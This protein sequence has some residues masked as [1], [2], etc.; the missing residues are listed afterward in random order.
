ME[1]FVILDVTTKAFKVVLDAKDTEQ[2]SINS[3][4]WSELFRGFIHFYFNGGGF[5][6]IHDVVDT[7]NGAIRK[8]SDV[9]SISESRENGV[10]GRVKRQINE[11]IFPVLD[12]FDL[13]YVP[14]YGFNVRKYRKS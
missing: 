9:K 10:W 5:D 1:I 6:F 7:R 12:P 2:L 8:I 13:S 4:S 11:W 3:D 14:S